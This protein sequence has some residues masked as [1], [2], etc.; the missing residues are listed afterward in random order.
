MKFWNTSF[1]PATF[2]LANKQR[3]TEQRAT[4]QSDLKKLLQEN[5]TS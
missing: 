4:V 1:F 3:L 2:F 5:A